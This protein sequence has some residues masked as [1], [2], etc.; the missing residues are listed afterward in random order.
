VLYDAMTRHYRHVFRGT[1]SP[2]DDDW[3]I[4]EHASTLGNNSELIEKFKAFK[5]VELNQCKLKRV[6][7]KIYTLS[8][9]IRS[10]ST[11]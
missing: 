7:V 2:F 11:F 4:E 8:L 6:S 1:L 9:V 10:A 5:L 3:K